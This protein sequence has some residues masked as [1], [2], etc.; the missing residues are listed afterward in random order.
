ME[1]IG[2]L[3]LRTHGSTGPSAI[4]LHGGPAAAG[5]AAPL[6]HGLSDSFQILEP[7]QRG[8]GA[9]PLTVASHIADLHALITSRCADMRPALVGESWGAMLALAYAAAHP[10]TVAAVVLVGCGTFDPKSRARLRATLAERKTAALQHQL[11]A[12]VEA[13]PDP[14]ERLKKEVALTQALYAYA[15]IDAALDEIADEPFDMVAHNETWEDML[16][17][18]QAGVY[19]AAF[20]AITSPVLMLHG[21]YDPHPGQ[22]IRAS[23]APYIRRLEYVEWENCGH[24][25]WAEQFVR[26][27][28]FA[29]LREWLTRQ[30]AQ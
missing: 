23:L 5:S 30:L 21:K 29:V 3:R 27:E 17:L 1:R 15:P 12:L 20:A 6:A 10:E 25:P 24:S 19:P 14:A 26:D 4:V 7:W 2:A 11:E 22:M 16:R 9:K 13:F 18:Q 8:S 28:F